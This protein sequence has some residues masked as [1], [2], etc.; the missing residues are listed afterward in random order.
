VVSATVTKSIM[1]KA[2]GA[3]QR[4]SPRDDAAEARLA[5]APTN[6]MPSIVTDIPVTTTEVSAVA[7]D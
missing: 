7:A 5:A 3:K 6:V 4:E 2:A 1:A